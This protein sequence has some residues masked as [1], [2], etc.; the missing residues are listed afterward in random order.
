MLT[1]PQA[2][3]DDDDGLLTA[4]EIAN[5]RLDADWVVLSACNTAGGGSTDG[6]EALSGL[7]RAFFYA[8]ARALLV[9]HWYV[10]SNATVSLITRAFA[11]L[12]DNPGIGR[13]E[14]LR[15]SQSAMI[16]GG[17]HPANWAPFVVVGEG[18]STAEMARIAAPVATSG[19]PA[20]P[21]IKPKAPRSSRK[22]AQGR[23]DA[24]AGMAPWPPAGSGP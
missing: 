6:G 2:A 12:R 7:A 4:S 22:S 23:A 11:E 5:L 16:A 19:K 8:G 21:T 1:P 20:V 17:E 3:T 24:K 14:A 18:A 15:R 10:N 13:A 9:S